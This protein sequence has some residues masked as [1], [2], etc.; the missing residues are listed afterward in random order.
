MGFIVVSCRERS[1]PSVPFWFCLSYIHCCHRRRKG[2]DD[3]IL[4][5]V[6]L[7]VLMSLS[8]PS[9]SS[10]VE[11]ERNVKAMG[12]TKSTARADREAVVVLVAVVVA[13]RQ[14]AT[15]VGYREKEHPETTK[16]NTQ[17]P[18]QNSTPHNVHSNV[19][20][21]RDNHKAQ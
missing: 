6:L 1:P 2:G 18:Q 17:Q 14:R 4:K 13:R 5:N 15:T 21:H 16:N 9:V 20:S 10:L 12:Q 19:R 3:E 7:L 8:L 11:T